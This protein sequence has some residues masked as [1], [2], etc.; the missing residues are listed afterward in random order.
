M[1]FRGKHS[2]IFLTDRNTII[3]KFNKD[4]LLN[5]NKEKFFLNFL[6]NYSFVPKILSYDNNNLEIEMEYIDGIYFKYIDR[7]KKIDYLEKLLDILFLLD[8]LGIEKRE[9]TRP[10]Y[11]IILK[12][13]N[14]YLIDWERAT[15]KERPSN[16]TQFLQYIIK[17]YNIGN[18]KIF[19]LLKLYKRNY[20]I[21]NYINIKRFIFNSL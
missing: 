11:H 1:I 2:H 17:Y 6:R 13:D 15:I 16:L 8:R 9:F 5:Y 21:Y 12:D 7:S 4:L 19:D 20:T 10:Y 3:K 18:N 14:I